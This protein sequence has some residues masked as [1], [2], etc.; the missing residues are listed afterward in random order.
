MG[1]AL[2]FRLAKQFF[3][4]AAESAGLIR[5]PA[6]SSVDEMRDYYVLI[7][8]HAAKSVVYL[9]VDNQALVSR[10]RAPLTEEQVLRLIH[11]MPEQE[12]RWIEDENMPQT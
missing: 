5:V 2:C 3:T 11:K 1:G 7:P 8:E 6:G 12:C 10:M 4:A 9:P